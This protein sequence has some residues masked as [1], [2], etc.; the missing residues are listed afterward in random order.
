MLLKCGPLRLLAA[1]ISPKAKLLDAV[2]LW[3]SVVFA[4]A[5][6]AVDVHIRSKCAVRR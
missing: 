3:L 2:L 6:S 4:M 1:A 5:S